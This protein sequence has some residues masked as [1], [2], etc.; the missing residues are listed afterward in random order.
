VTVR[1]LPKPLVA[2]GI[3]ALL[4]QLSV[5]VL[6]HAHRGLP[7]VVDD[8]ALVAVFTV[9][10]AAVVLRAWREPQGRGAWGLVAAG[11]GVYTAGMVIFNVWISDDTGAPF[12]SVADYM[13]LAVQ[14]CAIVAVLRAGRGAQRHPSAAELLDGLTCALA[15][16]AVCGAVIYE[17]MYDR[18]VAHGATFALVLP[19]LDLAVVATVIVRISIRG[20]RPDRFAWLMFGAFLAL[21]CGDTWYVAQAATVG[22]D[23]GSWVDLPYAVCMSALALAAWTPPAPPRRAEPTSLRNLAIP[24]TAGLAGVVLASFELVYTFNP[25]AEAATVLLM[26]TV[27]VRAAQAMRGY[28]TLL[29]IK[30]HEAGTDALT[31]LPNRRRLLEDLTGPGDGPRTLVLFDLDGFKSYN[32]TFGHSAGDALLVRLAVALQAAVDGRGTA[33]RMGGDE[34]CVL[35]HAAETDAVVDAAAAALTAYEDEVQI[36]SSWGV[37]VLPDEAATFTEALGIADRRMY[38]M[39]NGRPR[40]AGSQL[41]EV[42]VRVLDIREPDLHDHVLDVGRLA[43]DVA[44]HLGLPEHEITD[45]VHGA[46]LHDVGKLAVPESILAKPG[47]LDD[48]EWEIVRRHTIEGEQFLAG[49]P[50][51]ANVARLVRSSHERW[52]GGGYPDG[53]SGED[54]PLGARIITV[55]DAYDAMVTDRPYRKGMPRAAALSELRRCA[56]SHFD[57]CVVEAFC[58]MLGAAGVTA[59][60]VPGDPLRRLAA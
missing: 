54:I 27:V 56:G 28:G 4:A 46:V 32:D 20:W 36:S 2:A 29:M 15:L 34:F 49:I 40:S 23:P 19:L 57:A 53:L 59:G 25:V 37:V 47:P 11:L 35:S 58:A 31:G 22:W 14:P 38:A 10:L 48:A 44:R 7:G 5:A 33:Y 17:P 6:P 21:S 26:L 30:V 8:W 39:K 43:E 9:A 51:L 52:D 60:D 1:H 16:A 3:A 41:R 55:C 42:L 45:I 12:P 13:W 24:I 18:V 50:A